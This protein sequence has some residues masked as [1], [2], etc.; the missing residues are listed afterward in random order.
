MQKE[1][2]IIQNPPKKEPETGKQSYQYNLTMRSKESKK[3]FQHRVNIE[4]SKE[5]FSWT[6]TDFKV[7]HLTPSDKIDRLYTLLNSPL[8]TISLGCN[9]G[10]VNK[11][12]NQKDI[13]TKW[14]EVKRR[15]EA[16]YK[17]DIV[18]KLLAIYNKHY[19]SPKTILQYLQT[20]PIL[21]LFYRNY[22][23]DYLVYYGHSEISH[24]YYEEVSKPP[25]EIKGNK[26]LSLTPSKNLK[27]DYKGTS[28]GDNPLTITDSIELDYDTIWIKQAKTIITTLEQDEEKQVV[29]AL[30]SIN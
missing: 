16:E 4:Y 17:G 19:T 23:N 22:L 9:Q 7:N 15:I 21:Q 27:L 14:K 28:K 2:Y 8:N 24:N 13:E 1:S 10:I 18:K 29:I 20:N 6:K 12:H 26:I 5:L 11:L 30:N 3:S 25:V